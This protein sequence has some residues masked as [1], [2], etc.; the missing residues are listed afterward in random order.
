M[1]MSS[2]PRTGEPLPPRLDFRTLL[3]GLATQ[4]APGPQGETP[5]DAPYVSAS[6]LAG[7]LCLAAVILGRPGWRDA[8]RALGGGFS[9]AAEA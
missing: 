1:D 6:G 7:D 4:A 5:D 9:V 2:H 3:A 8:A